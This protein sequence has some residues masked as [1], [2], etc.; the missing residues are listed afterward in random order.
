MKQGDIIE[1]IHTGNRSSNTSLTMVKVLCWS[2]KT[3][4]FSRLGAIRTMISDAV[5]GR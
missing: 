4:Q 5:S 1:S 3:M 2:I